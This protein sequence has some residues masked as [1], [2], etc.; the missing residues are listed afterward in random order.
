MTQK[1]EINTKHKSQRTFDYEKN[2][3]TLVFTLR[4]DR[5]DELAAFSAILELAQKEVTEE[6][7]RAI[8]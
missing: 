7:S 8:L 2:G 6:L 4:I 3:I 1:V 5:K